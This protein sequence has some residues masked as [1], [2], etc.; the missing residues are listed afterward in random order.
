M[1]AGRRRASGR[2]PFSPARAPGGQGPLASALGAGGGAERR[3]HSAPWRP[4]GA[5]RA[6]PRESNGSGRAPERRERAGGSARDQSGWRRARPWTSGGCRSRD[7]RGSGPARSVRTGARCRPRRGGSGSAR[8][9]MGLCCCK[10]WRGR[11][12][13]PKGNSA[14]GRRGAGPPR[15]SA[16][17]A[18]APLGG[19][20]PV[21]RASRHLPQPGKALRCGHRSP[22]LRTLECAS[23]SSS[24][25]TGLAGAW[26]LAQGRRAADRR[27]VHGGGGGAR[28]PPAPPAGPPPRE[29]RPRP[30]RLCGLTAAER[31]IHSPRPTLSLTWAQACFSKGLR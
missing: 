3:S 16:A 20:R 17:C 23:R 27:Q 5:R 28:P 14:R 9:A 22:G 8:G 1:G 15:G 7:A 10:D 6:A 30:R 13:A 25:P 26:G 24:C 2:T 4:S 11:L 12:R 29:P 21:L 18:P 31:A 19:W